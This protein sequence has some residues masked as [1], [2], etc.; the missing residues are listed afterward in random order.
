MLKKRIIKDYLGKCEDLKSLAKKFK[1]EG[2]SD[3]IGIYSDHI[4]LLP[5][6]VDKEAKEFLKKYENYIESIH[7]TD[8]QTFLMT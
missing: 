5:A 6:L 2:V 8:R 1:V 3:K 4:E 7:I